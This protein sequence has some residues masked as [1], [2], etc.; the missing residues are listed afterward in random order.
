M[1]KKKKIYSCP[2]YSASQIIIQMI[3]TIIKYFKLKKFVISALSFYA[4]S[5]P[6]L[7]IKRDSIKYDV[8]LSKLIDVEIFL[9][10]W[11][12]SAIAFFKKSLKDEDIVIEVGA[13]I[14]AH[15]L[16]IGKLIGKKGRLIAIEPTEYA[17]R[18]LN[19]NISLNEDIS[20]ITVIDKIISDDE[21]KG[22]DIFNSDWSTKSTQSPCSIEFYSSTV[23]KVVEECLLQK[24][25]MLK[26]DVDG[27]DFRVLKGA[28]K[29]IER[30]KPI[31]FVE[32]CQYTLNEKGA[33]ISG[34][35]SYLNSFGYKCFTESGAIIDVDKVITLVG[36]KT[37]IN[38]IFKIT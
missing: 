33:S 29:T 17:L 30:F 19:R 1:S 27:Y 7:I 12:K 18:K 37:S 26:V 22:K 38:G 15:S 16:L 9:G 3:R 13:N 36:L 34:I 8:D 5:R 11:E 6:N 23:D 35:F 21:Y 24:V 2:K 4:R 28:K 31:I 25:D 14:G 32:L 20:N 10:G